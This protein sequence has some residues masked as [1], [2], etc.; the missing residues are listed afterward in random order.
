[1]DERFTD[2]VRKV[3]ALA[4][5]EARRR[6]D[7]FIATEHILLGLVSEGSG[8]A[9]S[10]LKGCGVDLAT[11]RVELT[12]W[13]RDGA[14]T[15]L[16]ASLPHSPRADRVIKSAIDEARR[17]NHQYVDTEHLLLGLLREQD[18]VAT[19]VLIGM[20]L[21]LDRVRAAV[22]E[23]LGTGQPPASPPE[24][25]CSFDS[26]KEDPT[27]KRMLRLLETYRAEIKDAA[28]VGYRDRVAALRV[29]LC[30]LD[31]TLDRFWKSLK[32]N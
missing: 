22:T 16:P 32:E 9:A 11:V 4:D 13:V 19:T 6:K 28:D 5:Q 27:V 31:A 14:G 29:I 10:V 15:G 17:L 2:R 7:D 1:M 3:M 23:L 18:S 8:V 30:D 12:R 26:Y 25:L 20:G 24:P 21:E